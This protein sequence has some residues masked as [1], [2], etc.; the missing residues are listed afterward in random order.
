MRLG[1]LAILSREEAKLA[2]GHGR[3]N[4]GLLETVDEGRCPDGCQDA[5][6]ATGRT[7]KAI[8]LLCRAA[9]RL[10]V[11]IQVL[12]CHRVGLAVA[13]DIG[14]GLLQ[15]ADQP[16]QPGFSVSGRCSPTIEH[17]LDAL[18][19]IGDGL[20]R[21]GSRRESIKAGLNLSG[22]LIDARQAALQ[23]IETLKQL[24]NLQV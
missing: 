18:T 16:T 23:L 21:P 13:I 2:F 1:L 10:L 4:A 9:Q 14:P 3:F 6:Q 11:A 22:R 19:L 20:Q 5:L 15:P 12:R 24:P 17:P 8:G 7:G